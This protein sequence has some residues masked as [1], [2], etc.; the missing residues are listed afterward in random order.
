M[1]TPIPTL[2]TLAALLLA[3]PALAD[4]TQVFSLVGADCGDCGAEAQAVLK[5]LKGVKKTSWDRDKVELTA[6][7]AD[8]VKDEQLVAAIA[9]AKHEF[10]LEVG[11][12]KGAYLPPAKWPEGA[13]V[14]IVTKDGS[15]VGPLEK[16]RVPGKTTVFDFYA[17]WCGPCRV[18]DGRLRQLVGTR[19]DVAVRKLNVVRFD[20]PLAKELGARLKALPYVIV[21]SP[22]GR[23]T[24]IVGDAPA[25][26][27]AALGAK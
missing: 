13:D 27:A 7:L 16:L 2:A 23:R 6:V 8:G 26:L 9:A 22:D 5:K 3:A 11:P 4:R 12:G 10:H 1:R 20:T 19:D 24:E 14:Q 17:D 21:Y 18:V 25:K 15:A